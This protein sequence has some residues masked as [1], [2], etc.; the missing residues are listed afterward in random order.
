MAC[1]K[2]GEYYG[3]NK[4]DYRLNKQMDTKTGFG[5]SSSSLMAVFEWCV[6]EGNKKREESISPF[7][8][9][10]KKNYNLKRI[11]IISRRDC[12]R[13]LL[14]V[15]GNDHANIRFRF[16]WLYSCNT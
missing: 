10:T 7:S 9:L 6:H 14:H 11:M 3:E 12:V 13:N 15:H 1:Q 4:F 8:R 16:P 5:K 2:F